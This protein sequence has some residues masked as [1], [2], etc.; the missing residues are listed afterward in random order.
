MPRLVIPVLAPR[1]GNKFQ[2]T[3]SP[4][5]YFLKGRSASP[6]T[7]SIAYPRIFPVSTDG[8]SGPWPTLV[9]SIDAVCEYTIHQDTPTPVSSLT[10]QK[11]TPARNKI[12]FSKPKTKYLL[13][14]SHPPFLRIQLS[15]ISRRAVLPIYMGYSTILVRQHLLLL[16]VRIRSQASLSSS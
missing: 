2:T 1:R 5:T 6:W 14:T 7:E 11:L 10:C 15:P 13:W 4:P 9:L 12:L 16:S 3:S 8:R